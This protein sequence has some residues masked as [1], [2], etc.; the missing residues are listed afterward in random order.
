MISPPLPKNATE[1][2]IVQKEWG[3][4]RSYKTTG[5][6]KICTPAPFDALRQK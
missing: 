5:G 3:V 2:K 1:I 6:A 4:E